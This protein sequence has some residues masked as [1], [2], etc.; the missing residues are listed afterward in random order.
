M[1][2]L[3]VSL[4]QLTRW[5]FLGTLVLTML[6]SL[7]P[8]DDV[9]QFERRLRTPP[10]ELSLSSAAIEKFPAAFDQYFGDF[11][12]FRDFWVG[13]HLRFRSRV[14]QET[15]ISNTV[16]G[17]QGWLYEGHSIESARHENF[18][19]PT[20]ANVWRENR[21][22]RMAWFSRRKIIY[23]F[24]PVPEKESIYPEFFPENYVNP[25]G[26]TK[27]ITLL[28][29]IQ[30]QSWFADLR[31]P[32]SQ[33]KTTGKFP[34]YRKLDSHWNGYG[35][36]LGYREIMNVYHSQGGKIAG[37]SLTRSDFTPQLAPTGD[38]SMIAD[39][40]IGRVEDPSLTSADFPLH[41]DMAVYD[42]EF[43]PKLPRPF[44]RNISLSKSEISI[45]EC[46]GNRGTVL[47]NGDSYSF[48]LQPYLQATFHRVIVGHGLTPSS[49]KQLV[50]EEKPDLFVEELAERYLTNL[51]SDDTP[52]P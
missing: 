19:P 47:V 39:L 33:E 45:T 17:K 12:G 10:P 36:Y 4:E 52:A 51:V 11:S 15:V 18:N 20:T 6:A 5:A 34:V 29:K 28:E 30:G 27:T 44:C 42:F 41:A 2:R 23:A 13:L 7:N 31:G 50:E 38:L 40:P 14:L 26:T 16:R 21:L 1:S 3:N 24:L 22:S 9:M 48:L 46:R 25:A 8:V 49:L 37:I 32:M 43:V 35:A